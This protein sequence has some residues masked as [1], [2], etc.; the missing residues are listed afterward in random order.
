MKQ[1]NRFVIVDVVPGTTAADHLQGGDEI[2]QVNQQD[3]GH[4]EIS[5][6][7]RRRNDRFT[8][9]IVARSK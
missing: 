1:T 3:M 8:S 2:L 9:S 7:V 4:L 5:E 6:F